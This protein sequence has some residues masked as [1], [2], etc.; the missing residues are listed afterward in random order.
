MVHTD[1][2][3]TTVIYHHRD[4]P[5][6]AYSSTTYFGSVLSPEKSEEFI[7]DL[8]SCLDISRENKD[9][10]RRKISGYTH[11]ATIGAMSTRPSVLI[12]SIEIEILKTWEYNKGLDG[13]EDIDRAWMEW[14][15]RSLIKV[16][17]EN[18]SGSEDGFSQQVE[19]L[20]E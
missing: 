6:D 9:D 7:S 3:F 17:E 19:L 15:G 8:I 16:F 5:V 11:D 1:Q 12:I 14:R 2:G 20:K 10:L 4:I 18:D 13:E